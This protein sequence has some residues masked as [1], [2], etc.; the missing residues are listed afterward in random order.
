MEVM[1]SLQSSFREYVVRLCQPWSIV[2]C[3]HVLLFVCCCSRDAL[4]GESTLENVRRCVSRSRRLVAVLG[5][6]W[7][8]DHVL[9]TAVREGTGVLMYWSNL[10]Q[11]AVLGEG[12]NSL[13]TNKNVSKR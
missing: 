6:D 5:E 7:R 10:E 12:K 4:L 9:L 2:D 3:A 13:S 11:A 1:L 8:K